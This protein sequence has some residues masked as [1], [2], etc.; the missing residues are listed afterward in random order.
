M[1]EIICINCP[2]GCLM[3]VT[4]DG[5]VS[6]HL[7][8]R[9][10]DYAHE[11]QTNPTRNIT[12][13]VRVRGGML[14]TLSVKS[15]RPIPKGKIFDVMRAIKKINPAAPVHMGDVILSNA[16]D[17]GV[18]IIATRHVPERAYIF[19][20]D[21]TLL[22]SAGIW[23]IINRAFFAKR[24][25]PFPEDYQQSIGAMPF[26]EVARYTKTRFNLPETPEALM[27]EFLTDSI[28]AYANDVRLKPGAKE[29]LQRLRANGH[30]MAVATAAPRELL[31]PALQNHG[32]YDLF[33][34]ICT[35]QDVSKGK[36]HPDIFLLAAR[37]INAPVEACLVFD[38]ILPAIQTAHALGMATCGLRDDQP[39]HVWAQIQALADYTLVDFKDAML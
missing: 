14:P 38:D 21:G 19:D 5:E 29:Y 10:I 26:P 4:P 15:A 24:N 28:N 16:A 36:T 3:T 30:K 17:T 27:E 7:C 20:L 34:A 32:I 18:D 25:I 23:N 2:A 31:T 37:S 11:E 39:D 33:N 35:T 22:D 1:L 8:D 6:G 13:S 9:G 12:T